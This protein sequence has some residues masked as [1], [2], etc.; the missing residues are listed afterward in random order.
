MPF[1]P[2]FQAWLDAER[3][4]GLKL[5]RIPQLPGKPIIIDLEHPG[6]AKVTHGELSEAKQRDIL[7]IEAALASCERV[8]RSWQSVPA[9]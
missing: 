9:D 4:R 6:G 8:H 2:E 5:V 3:A 1:T 7:K